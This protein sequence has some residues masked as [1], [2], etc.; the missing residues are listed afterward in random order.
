LIYNSEVARQLAAPPTSGRSCSRYKLGTSRIS[1]GWV[2]TLEM[3]ISD[4]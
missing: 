3:V 4:R 2:P 1:T